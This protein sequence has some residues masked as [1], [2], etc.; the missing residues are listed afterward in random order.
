MQPR[1]SAFSLRESE[2]QDSISRDS[3]LGYDCVAG[4]SNQAAGTIP[5]VLSLQD[6]RHFVRLSGKPETALFC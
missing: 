4:Y 5:G 1:L 6:W 3:H 2:A